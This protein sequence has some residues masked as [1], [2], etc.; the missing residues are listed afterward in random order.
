MSFEDYLEELKDQSRALI[1]S[2]LTKL[3]SIASSEA[4]A[5]REA[6]P[7]AVLNRRR[8][9]MRRLI[10]L[11]EDNVDLDFDAVYKVALTDDDEEVRHLA[12]QGLWEYEGRDLIG[13]LIDMLRH[14]S[15]ES[16]RAQAALALGRYVLRAEFQRLHP[17]DGKRIEEAL[18]AAINNPDEAV[19]VRGRALEAVGALSSPWV[20]E[21]I[22]NAYR[23]KHHR[24][25]ISAMHAMGRACDPR[26][27]PLI[28]QELS[29]DEEE[30]RFEA[31]HACGLVCDEAAVPRLKRLLRDRDVEV[32]EA[33][34]ASLGEIGGVEAREALEGLQSH[35]NVRVREAAVAAMDDLDFNAD[36]L[37]FGLGRTDG[38]S[39]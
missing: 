17:A 31:A 33:A 19:E 12:I 8:Q 23:S 28:V 32:Q 26:W 5:L 35:P 30:M 7:Q 13:P 18:R 37:K 15:V 38:D 34:I 16:V 39:E 11:T 2:R 4:D 29:S 9:V 6:W 24:L 1:A 14:D 22:E 36:P 27:Q 10:D 3:S 21:S 20:H 25:R